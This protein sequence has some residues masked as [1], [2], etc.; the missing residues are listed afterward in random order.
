MRG[1]SVCRRYG[2]ERHRLVFVDKTSAGTKNDAP[3][4]SLRKGQRL[5]A[6]NTIRHWKTTRPSLPGARCRPSQGDEY[7]DRRINRAHLQDLCRARLAPTLQK[8]VLDFI[9]D[10]LVLTGAPS[11]RKDSK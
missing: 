4:W 2:F 6:K 9:L 10:D 1:R 7:I 11:G 5:K 8:V 3:T